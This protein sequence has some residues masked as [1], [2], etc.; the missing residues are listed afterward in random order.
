[1]LKGLLSLILSLCLWLSMPSSALAVL[2]VIDDNFSIEYTVNTKTQELNLTFKLQ[3][4]VN[5]WMGL[6]FHE[7]MFPSD[8]IV[9]WM[10]PEKNFHALDTYNPGIPTLS[11]FPSPI[12]DTNPVIKLNGGS[13]FNNK[14]NLTDV[15]GTYNNGIIVI[16]LKRKLIT[17][18]IFDFQIYPGRQF[19]VVAAYSDSPWTPIYN[20][21]QASH[22]SYDAMTW[23]IEPSAYSSMP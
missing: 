10:G 16:S 3:N 13:Q 9:A 11:S 15:F 6:C 8:C 2:W 19:H 20:A 22:I 21:Q 12:Q 23:Y 14:N 7:F 5:G 1:M 18:D 17:E 4:E